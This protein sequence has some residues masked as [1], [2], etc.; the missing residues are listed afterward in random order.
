MREIKR[1]IITNKNEIHTTF[2]DLYAFPPDIQCRK[3]AESVTNPTAKALLYEQQILSDVS[4]LF[5]G[6]SSFNQRLFVPYVKPYVFECFLFVD[7]KTSAYILSD[8]DNAKSK[9][10]ESKIRIISQ[11][12]ESPEHINNSPNTAPSK[13][14]ETILPGFVK[15]KAGKVGYSY[16]AAQRAGLQNIRQA[17]RHFDEW[18]TKLEKYQQHQ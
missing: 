18:L 8:G 17:C 14:L 11:E 1:S 6:D 15:K 5:D 16:R 2:F 10:L 13:R 4:A 7:P 12:F 3:E 9:T